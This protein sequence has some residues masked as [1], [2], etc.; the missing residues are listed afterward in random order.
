MRAVLNFSYDNEP[1]ANVLHFRESIVP[2]SGDPCL[3]GEDLATWWSTE[4]APNVPSTCILNNV[5]VTDLSASGPPACVF[6]AG[7]PDSGG[8]ASAQL[9]NNATLVFSV[10]TLLRGRSFRGR[11]YHV[12]LG[13]TFVTGNQAVALLLA[14][15]LAAY[16]T[17][18]TDLGTPGTTGWQLG[19]LSYFTAGALRPQPVFT[20]ADSI[21]TDGVV[22]SQR[23]RLPG[24]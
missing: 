14:P 24:H 19:I 11:I 6:T 22:D 9:P 8:G 4:V 16:Q 3:L 23:R 5:T 7:L 20:D 15:L 12:G 10:R 2:A 21:S 13:E 17:L 1:A 18:V